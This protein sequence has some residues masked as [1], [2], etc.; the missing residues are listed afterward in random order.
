MLCI[1]HPNTDARF[2]LA[3]EEYVL[4]N[5]GDDIFMLWQNHNTIVVGKHQNTLAE[6]NYDY[7]KELDIRVVRRLSGGGAVYHDL[8]NLNFTFITN[9]QEGRLVD[10]K[11]FTLPILEVLK[12]LGI[13]ARFEGRNDL[14]I[15]GLKFSG[16][17]EHVYKNRVLHHGTLL[18]SSELGSLSMA[19]KVNPLKYHDKAV[20]SV[21][22]RVTNI[23]DHLSDD[24]TVEE[25][26]DLIMEHIFNVFPNARKYDFSPAD[27]EYIQLLVNEKYDTWQWNYGYSPKYAFHKMI[28]TPGGY[29]EYH[30]NVEEGTIKDIKI[31]GDFFS[32]REISELEEMLRN[33]PHREE[34]IYDKLKPIPFG[35]YLHQVELKDFVSGMF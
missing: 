3:A 20:K 23:R 31:F 16:N 26:R 18:F 24:L 5:F 13:D 19:L 17:A 30:L 33:L 34:V 35:E 29:I 12:N 11:K 14:T 15:N 8:G 25:F 4:K 22:S 6:I 28:K 27:I 2:N 32:F 21:R 10:F 9:G 7:V 1:K